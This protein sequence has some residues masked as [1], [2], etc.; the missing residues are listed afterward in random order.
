MHLHWKLLFSLI[1]FLHSEALDSTKQRTAKGR[2]Q[3]K[4]K[5]KGYLSRFCVL[6]MCINTENN[7]EKEKS[8]T[9]WAKSD[10]SDLETRKAELESWQQ[11]EKQRREQEEI[12]KRQKELDEAN[13][14]T[15]GP[16]MCKLNDKSICWRKCCNNEYGGPPPTRAPAHIDPWFGDE[17]SLPTKPPVVPIPIPF[18]GDY[19]FDTDPQSWH[20]NGKVPGT[21][22]EAK[23]AWEDAKKKGLLPSMFGGHNILD[24][25]FG[26]IAQSARKNIKEARDQYSKNE[27][28][29]TPE[30]IPGASAR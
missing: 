14:C 12:E 16:W 3:G 20:P 18:M 9:E 27:A 19:W 13:F 1:A 22:I 5:G 23:D 21:H 24:Q 8:D 28:Q 11:Q 2:G 30:T 10:A 17:N 29:K 26:G 25:I 15:C 6:G 4:N 7:I